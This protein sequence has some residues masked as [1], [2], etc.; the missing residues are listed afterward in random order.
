[1]E[2]EGGKK[3]IGITGLAQMKE[4][5][6][7]K[8]RIL[9]N[10]KQ[11]VLLK[12]ERHQVN[13]LFDENQSKFF[14]VLRDILKD[15]ESEEPLYKTPN[16]RPET[17]TLRTEDFGNYWRPLWETEAQTNL[18]ADWIQS[19][20]Q[21]IKSKV[22]PTSSNF[23]FLTEA[24]T[25]CVKKKKNWSSP[26]NDK[27]CNFWIKNFTSFH[28]ML[29]RALNELIQRD[30]E[31]P[32]WLPGPRTVMIKK[33]ENPAPED[34]RPITCLSNTY[35]VVTSVINEALKSHEKFQQLLQL[36]QRGSKPGSVVA[37]TIS[38]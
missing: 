2:K 22:K 34:H 17:S 28:A 11:R 10:E 27:T 9:K 12:L 8:I 35:K 29:C 4:T 1:M 36:D 38:C 3:D 13:K 31:F 26:G 23:R 24:F 19:I 7:N 20:E 6:L 14:K 37:L 16:T 33:R 18:D 30:A 15:D 32:A 21:L 5:R 25:K